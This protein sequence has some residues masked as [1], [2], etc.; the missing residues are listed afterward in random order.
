MS[1]LRNLLEGLHTTPIS[2]ETFDRTGE[3]AAQVSGA[4]FVLSLHVHRPLFQGWTDRGRKVVALLFKAEET[5]D[6]LAAAFAAMAEGFTIVPLYPNWSAETQLQYLRSYR[7]HALAVGP[8]FRA[9]AE[10]W[11][12]TEIDR[13]IPVDLRSRPAAAVPGRS[14]APFCLDVPRGHACAWI[15][16]SGTSG[17]VAKLTEITRENLEAA[18]ENIQ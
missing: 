12:G 10:S 8:G 1:V 6:F 4:D 5:V 11:L 3:L 7:L 9:R 15:F 14:P 16:T 13:L 2:L 17:T 18:I